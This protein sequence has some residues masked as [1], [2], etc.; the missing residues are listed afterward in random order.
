MK[1]INWA[2]IPTRSVASG[3]PNVWQL[4]NE[5]Q[6]DPIDCETDFNELEELFCLNGG[7]LPTPASGSSTSCPNS[8]RVARRSLPQQDDHYP[9]MEEMNSLPVCEEPK[10]TLVPLLDSKRSLSINIFLKQYKGNQLNEVIEAIRDGQHQQ[11]GLERLR[12]LKQI[13]PD[14]NELALLRQHQSDA[15]RMPLAERFLLV[16][17]RLGN[18]SLKIDFMLL[19][20][21]Y[22]ANMPSVE[23]ANHCLRTAA[24]QIMAS[25]KLQQMLALVLVAGNFLN[26]VSSPD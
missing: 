4:I 8:P 17:I 16:L 3:Q 11:I 15:G 24:E 18:Y 7:G 26:F 23:K 6:S 10:E 19:R 1:T 14:S 5:Q 12:I 13:L 21:E 20:Q 22:V 9:V 2:K 25:D